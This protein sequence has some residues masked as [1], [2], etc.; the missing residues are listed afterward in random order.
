MGRSSG[1]GKD[2]VESAKRIE[3]P[4]L[5]QL[6]YLPKGGDVISGTLRWSFNGEPSGNINITVNS[7]LDAPYIHFV[8]RS[9]NSGA[10][11]D[12]WIDRDYEFP[13]EKHSCRYGGNKWFFRCQL[14][15]NGVYCGRRVRV[16]YLVSGYFGC[17]HCANLTYQSCNYGGRY[18]GFL[19]IPDLE[20]QEARVKRTHYAGKPTRK[21]LRLLKMNRQFEVGFINRAA[22]LQKRSKK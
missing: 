13:L 18:K 9:K 8:Y 11:D 3:M 1:W 20:E 12:S 22:S 4:I 16:L 7:S 17:R 6:G 15:K 14:S 21:Y 19:S 10:S 5:K 2:T